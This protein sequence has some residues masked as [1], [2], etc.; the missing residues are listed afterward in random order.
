M[1]EGSHHLPG[2]AANL[3]G[4]AYVT[5]QQGRRDEA[6]AL[7]AEAGSIAESA[8]AYGILRQVQEAQAQLCERP[9]R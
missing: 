8:Q 1:L 5:A 3:V 2:V 4:L 6:L 9:T 7:L